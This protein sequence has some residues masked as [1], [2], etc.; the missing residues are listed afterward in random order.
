MDKIIC[1]CED[2]IDGIFT[3]IFKAWELGT[4]RTFIE[5]RGTK[6]MTLFSEYVDIETDCALASKVTTSIK[7]KLSGD[8]YAL[9]YQAALSDYIDKAQC[10]YEFLVKAFRIGKDIIN[11]LQDSS[12]MKVFELSRKVGYEIHRYLGFVRFAE[13]QNGVLSSKINPLAN[14]VPEVARHFA[15][16]LHNENWIILDT[17]RN[18]SA[19]HRANNGYILTNDITETML[20]SFSTQ[21]DQEL[22]FRELWNRFFDTIAI[23]ERKNLKLQQQVM[24]LRFRKYM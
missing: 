1:T 4:S 5:I 23:E 13:L 8:I 19:V 21:S 14:V 3:A 24:P 15:D 10:I 18:L 22:Q 7:N 11:Y 9:V 17:N 16:R 6:T 2:S 20:D 12:V